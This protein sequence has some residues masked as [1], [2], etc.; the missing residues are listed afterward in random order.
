MT[1]NQNN[2]GYTYLYMAKNLVG[3]LDSVVLVLFSFILEWNYS[4]PPN[5]VTVTVLQL[6]PDCVAW[7]SWLLL[8][9]RTD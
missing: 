1:D 4:P 2:K 5:I 9:S 6:I 3:K 7:I 8:T